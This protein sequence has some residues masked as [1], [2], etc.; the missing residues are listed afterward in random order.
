MMMDD[1][2]LDSRLY[3]W[4]LFEEAAIERDKKNTDVCNHHRRVQLMLLDLW[5][6]TNMFVF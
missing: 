4:W 5:Q 2:S 3:D 6:Q 1:S